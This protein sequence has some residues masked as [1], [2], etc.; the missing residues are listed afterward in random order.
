MRGFLSILAAALILVGV[1]HVLTAPADSVIHT[2][3]L[4]YCVQEAPTLTPRL[5]DEGLPLGALGCDKGRCPCAPR[6]ETR[7]IEREATRAVTITQS[8]A[9]GDG[10]GQGRRHVVIRAVVGAC[11]TIGGILG[12]DRRVAR[13][14]ARQDARRE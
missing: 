7:T 3:D 2:L 5:P 9:G 12:H 6:L 4:E 10:Q 11:K 8:A 1:G 14:Q 13:R